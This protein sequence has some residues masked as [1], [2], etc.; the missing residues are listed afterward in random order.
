MIKKKDC[1]THTQ[2]LKLSTQTLKPNKNDE[3]D[4]MLVKKKSPGL[5]CQAA[6]TADTNKAV[7]LHIDAAASLAGDKN[8][9]GAPRFLQHREK[10]QPD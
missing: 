7:S 3:A 9:C 8:L 2:A 6:C 1:R 10:Y 4:E 5:N